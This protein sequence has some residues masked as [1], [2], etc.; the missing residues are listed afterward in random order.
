MSRPS[1]DSDKAKQI[2]EMHCFAGR[3]LKCSDPIPAEMRPNPLD[4]EK[5]VAADPERSCVFK[6]QLADENR[7]TGFEV[8]GPQTGLQT[9]DVKCDQAREETCS[10]A[11]DLTMKETRSN[12]D[13]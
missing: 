6:I 8:A 1:S 3:G 11:G 10:H 2:Q 7:S 5:E 12:R 4:S 13:P 9:P